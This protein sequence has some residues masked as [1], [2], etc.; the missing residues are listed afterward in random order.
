MTDEETASHEALKAEF[1]ALNEQHGSADELPET[2][3]ERLGELETAMA[4]F[5]E[6][7]VC[8][9]PADIARAGIF[10]CLDH[11]GRLEIERGELPDAAVASVDASAFEPDARARAILRGRSYAETDLVET[12]G[13]YDL[14]QVRILLH[15]VSRQAVEKRVRD[16]SMIA[17][18]G[19]GHKRSYPTFQ[20]LSDGSVVDGLKPVQAALSTRNPWVVLGFLPIHSRPCA[21]TPGWRA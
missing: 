8:Y 19:P 10:V 12:G 11:E 4:A 2:V 15:G 21:A 18:P 14:D 13:A 6:R 9:D 16:G 7:P 17:V 3:D 5:D 20:F 1:D